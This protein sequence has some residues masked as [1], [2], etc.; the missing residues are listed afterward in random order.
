MQ[1]PYDA[2]LRALDR[3]MDALT[4]VIAASSAQLAEA[5]MLHHALIDKIADEVRLVAADSQ[6]IG[7]LY[8]VRARGERERR[9]TEVE[10]VASELDQ[11]RQRAARQYAAI[12]AVESAADQFRTDAHQ[13]EDRQ[14]QAM[15]DD[16]AAAR[17]ARLRRLQ[18]ATPR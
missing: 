7:D 13:A 3:E 16:I 1:T 10:H 2:A 12:R 14:Q 5:R 18:R 8:F 15:V 4:Q 9:A 17:F 6:L 11:L